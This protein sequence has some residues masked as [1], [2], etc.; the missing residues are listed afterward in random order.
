MKKILLIMLGCFWLSVASFCA[1][2]EE[3][4][5]PTAQETETILP[6]N[7]VIVDAAIAQNI[8]ELETAVFQIQHAQLESVVN[9]V[10]ELMGSVQGGVI[11]NEQSR[12]IEVSAPGQLL[13]KI[14]SLVLSLD[15]E[16]DVIVDFKVVQVDLNEEY[17]PGIN[18]SAIVSDYKSFTVPADD[19]TFSV[20]TVS[21]EDVTVLLE[22]LETV[23][24]VKMFPVQV[25]KVSNGQE[26]DLRLKAFD[27]D[28]VVGI[29]PVR[30]ADLDAQ[31][32]QDR[33]TARLVINPSV[34]RDEG[35]DFRIAAADGTTVV[36][37]VKKDSVAVLGGIFTQTKS[38]STRKFPFL[39]DL[40][41]FGVVFRDQ[42]KVVHRLENIILLT[43]R[44]SAP[45]NTVLSK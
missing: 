11:V 33:Y 19:R 13:T 21:Q 30:T 37:K 41:L 45:S 39:G 27:N 6:K 38:D 2:Q 16:Y 20:G 40:P 22:A 3:T 31:E 25:A 8:P 29:N 4:V 44:V 24:E 43:P 28:V 10:R 18:W 32:Q 26:A 9:Q 14:K 34:G 17:L 1:A 42:S 7:A 35:V 23:G 12:Q 15:K 5:V 36:V